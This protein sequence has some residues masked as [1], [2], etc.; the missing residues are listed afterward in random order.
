MDNIFKILNFLPMEIIY[1][2]LPY[3]YALQSNLLTNDIKNFYTT[4]ITVQKLYHYKY[5]VILGEVEPSNKDWL[6]NDLFGFSNQSIPLMNGYVDSFLNLFLRNISL[7]TNEEVLGYI[8][9][10]ETK[11]LNTQINIFWGLFSIEERNA[12]LNRVLKRE[13]PF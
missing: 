3:T 6:I 1:M 9:K 4:R 12:F 11:E 13:M 7:K 5:V 10:T 2:I 8:Q